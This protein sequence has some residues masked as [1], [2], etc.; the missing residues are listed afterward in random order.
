VRTLV[1]FDEDAPEVRRSRL[2]CCSMHDESMVAATGW[3]VAADLDQGGI[4]SGD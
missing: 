3:V 2:D 1:N 4:R